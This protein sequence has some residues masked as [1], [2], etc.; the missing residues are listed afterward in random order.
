[1]AGVP[2]RYQHFLEDDVEDRVRVRPVSGRP[3]GSHARSIRESRLQQV[4]RAARA[5]EIKL[6]A[7]QDINEVKADAYSSVRERYVR[8]ARPMQPLHSISPAVMNRW[9]VNYLRHERTSYDHALEDAWASAEYS[10]QLY[11]DE[12]RRRVLGLIA[13]RYPELEQECMNQR[14]QQIE[15]TS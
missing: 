1:M 9:V 14:A 11:R 8:E 7:P 4:V 3:S 10:K 12:V 2:A 13:S 6:R 5:V 15:G